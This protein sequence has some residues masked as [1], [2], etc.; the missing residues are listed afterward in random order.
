MVVVCV[1]A[2]V[3]G[4]AG[5]LGAAFNISGAAAGTTG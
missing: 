5:G 1:C 3:V 2:K 4:W